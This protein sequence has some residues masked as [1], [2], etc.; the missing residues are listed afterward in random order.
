MKKEETAHVPP[1]PTAGGK[2]A[3]AGRKPNSGKFKEPTKAIRVPESYVAPIMAWLDNVAMAEA[4]TSLNQPESLTRGKERAKSQALISLMD[5]MRTAPSPAVLTMPFYDCSVSAG[6]PSPADDSFGIT[7][8]LNK[9]LVQ[10]A[11]AT[12]FVRTSGESMLNAGIH[13]GD[14]LVVDRSLTAKNQDI[15][16]AAVDGDLTVKRLVQ[17]NGR[18]ILQAE[19]PLFSNIEL[20][21][22]MAVSL[23]GVVTNVIHSL[24]A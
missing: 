4:E 13:D 23:W 20:T 16:I 17:S 5:V 11:P 14:L 12:F 21:E 7:M 6:F 24:R 2:R 8:D 19:N 22:D 18:T 3:G 10:N 1:R 15:V 9:H